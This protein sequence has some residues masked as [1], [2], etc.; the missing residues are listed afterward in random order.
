MRLVAFIAV[1]AALVVPGVAQAASADVQVG[2]PF[3]PSLGPSVFV[4]APLGEPVSL[5]AVGSPCVSTC[6]TWRNPDAGLV[7]Y[8]GVILGYGPSITLTP[9]TVGA[10][11]VALRY[12]VKTSARFQKCASTIVYITTTEVLS[13]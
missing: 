11:R 10:S 2:D 9:V 12:C 5:T 7:R 3:A 1:F 13:P 4:T 6:Y 8:G